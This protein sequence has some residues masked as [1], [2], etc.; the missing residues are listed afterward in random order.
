[1]SRG[2][3]PREHEHVLGGG[4]PV[5]EHLQGEA[6]SQHSRGGK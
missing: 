4:G 5:A 2:D 6:S 3:E 1:M